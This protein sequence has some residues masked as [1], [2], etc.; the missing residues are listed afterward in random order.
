MK[1]SNTKAM[2]NDANKSDADPH[3]HQENESGG[4]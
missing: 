3:H 2:A 1:E 4:L